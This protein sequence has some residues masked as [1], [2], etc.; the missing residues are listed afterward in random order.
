M[1]SVV[2]KKRTVAKKTT[3]TKARKGVSKK[4][5][6]PRVK[7]GGK[8]LNDISKYGSQIQQLITE[9]PEQAQM[10]IN[11]LRDFAGPQYSLPPPKPW[12]QFW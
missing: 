2:K 12:Y 3:T 7:R 9:N 11:K 6:R 5:K 1:V 8:L 4:T 10:Y